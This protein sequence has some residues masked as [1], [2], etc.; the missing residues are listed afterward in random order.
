ME[1][2]HNHKATNPV[3]GCVFCD[4]ESRIPDT[5]AYAPGLDESQTVYAFGRW[6]FVTIDKHI[7]TSAPTPYFLIVPY[8]HYT[9]YAQLSGDDKGAELEKLIAF[10]HFA[11]LNDRSTAPFALN[12]VIFEHGQMRQG[13][14]VKS[15]YHAHLH[16]LYGQF[17]AEFLMASVLHEMEALEIPFFLVDHHRNYLETLQTN[18]PA[19]V[20]YLYFQVNDTCV[21]AIDEGNERIYSQFFRQILAKSSGDAFIN[22][23]TATED[24]HQIFCERLYQSLP[25][26]PLSFLH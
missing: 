1:K 16:V 13:N 26:N 14:K 11:V 23:K 5:L 22:W 4:A 20:D 17:A 19:G 10:T 8:D 3:P 15:V 6:F 7:V 12:R 25:L 18:V 9:S 2:N 24:E 21:V